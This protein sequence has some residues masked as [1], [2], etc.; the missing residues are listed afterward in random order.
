MEEAVKGKN[1]ETQKAKPST[2]PRH[3]PIEETGT[4]PPPNSD[5]ASLKPPVYEGPVGGGDHKH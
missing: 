1:S 4:A 2:D 5:P 3:T